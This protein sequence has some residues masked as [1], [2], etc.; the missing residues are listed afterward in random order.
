MWRLD[1]RGLLLDP[2][3]VYKQR[4]ENRPDTPTS[5]ANWKK[6]S[7]LPVICGNIAGIMEPRTLL[8]SLGSKTKREKKSHM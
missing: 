1:L 6:A 3:L 8:L 5:G 2:P 7:G 4:T